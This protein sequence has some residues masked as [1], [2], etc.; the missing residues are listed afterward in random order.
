MKR[1]LIAMYLFSSAILS[2]SAQEQDSI[3]SPRAF[4]N[5]GFAG[6][7]C[8]NGEK[9]DETTNNISL[10]LIHGYSYNVYGFM[11]APFATV[12]KSMHGLQTGMINLASD[13]KGVQAGF[14][15]NAD[16]LRGI[17]IGGF[18]GINQESGGLQIG[19]ANSRKSGG[20]QIGLVNM[21][22]HNNYPIGLINIIKDGDMY[23][24]IMTDEMSNFTATF[25]SGGR[26]LYGIAGFGHS[27]ASSLNQWILE[28]G[29][30]IHTPIFNRL[31]IDTEISAAL[32]TKFYGRIYFGDQEEAERKAEE[33][34]YKT[35]TK[36]SFRIMPTYRFGKR[37]E[38]F[39]GPSLN[40]LQSHCMEN[41]R[42]FPSNY[43]WRKFTS[44]SLKQVYWGWTAGVQYKL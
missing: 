14:G 42:I 18:N 22:E 33:Y 15:N 4:L 20:I 16:K 32:I 34:N 28:G 10:S 35:A 38:V 30:G 29:I 41:E 44:S 5:L 11:L 25:R 12:R 36:Y 2:S 17:Q 24:G 43:M 8:T 13:M 37:I 6:I 21:A 23:A 31:R 9:T 27:F 1:T 26:Y 19:L 39:G 40:Y 7:W 3:D